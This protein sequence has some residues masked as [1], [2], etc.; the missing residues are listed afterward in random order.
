MS[1]WEGDEWKWTW[2]PQGTIGLSNRSKAAR[3]LNGRTQSMYWMPNLQKV[4]IYEGQSSE[5]RPKFQ[6]RQ[7]SSKGSRCVWCFLFKCICYVMIIVHISTIDWLLS[8]SCGLLLS[9]NLSETGWRMF[10]ICFKWM[11]LGKCHHH[12]VVLFGLEMVRVTQRCQPSLALKQS[13]SNP[14]DWRLQVDDLLFLPHEVAICWMRLAYIYI[15]VY[16]YIY[17]KWWM[18]NFSETQSNMID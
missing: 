7:G 12:Q 15:Y 6:Q 11:S 18:G 14:N 1:E 13:E 2:L 16:I 4:L 9:D 17:T 8:P 3:W 10:S 5:A